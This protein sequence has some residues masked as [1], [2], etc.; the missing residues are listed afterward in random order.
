MEGINQNNCIGKRVGLFDILYECDYKS[1]DGHRLFRVRCSECGWETDV[2][3][4]NIKY[5]GTQCR[6]KNI[7][8]EYINFNSF[9]WRNQKIGHIFKGMKRRC[10]DSSHKSYRCYGAKGIKVCEE[11]I[12]DP[13]TFEDWALNNGYEDGL[14]IDRIDGNKDYCPENCRW[15]PLS[16][17]SRYKSSTYHIEVDGEIH[18][19]KEWAKILGFGVNL[20][21][22]YVKLYGIENTSE[23]I[24]RYLQNP[25]DK[26]GPN[27][28]FYNIYM[29][30]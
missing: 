4:R 18:S 14:T 7:N 13:K 20:I 3:F 6:H 26:I 9:K 12:N 11:W 27:Q 8:G 5:M 21:N 1:N 22:R 17:N 25:Q 29:K 15:V 24:H 23:F 2:A 19:G 28:S 16:D 10:Y 30:S